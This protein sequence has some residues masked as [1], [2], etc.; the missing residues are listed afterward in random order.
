[1]KFI[2][3][4]CRRIIERSYTKESII[5]DIAEFN[6]RV[7]Y[8]Q[9]RL[10]DVYYIENCVH[11]MHYSW[12][13]V[14]RLYDKITICIEMVRVFIDALVFEQKV[15]GEYR[16]ITMTGVFI[17][18]L[19]ALL[20]FIS[21]GVPD[22]IFIAKWFLGPGLPALVISAIIGFATLTSTTVCAINICQDTPLKRLDRQNLW[23]NM[24]E[25]AID[26]NTG[27]GRI[28]QI[29]YVGLNPYH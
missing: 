29:G 8:F 14:H 22:C 28:P 5:Y 15:Q 3:S 6:G 13:D 25:N 9:E 4:D 21:F 27:P 23:G 17:L 11:H 16:S 10:R 12:S 7:D 1:M 18:F 26:L 2:T 19:L 20:Y 24:P